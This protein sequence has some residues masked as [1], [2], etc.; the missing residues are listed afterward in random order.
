MDEKR[1]KQSMGER[2]LF[3]QFANPDC[4]VAPGGQNL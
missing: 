2:R 4:Y 1:M 3:A